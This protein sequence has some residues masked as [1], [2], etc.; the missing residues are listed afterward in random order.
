VVTAPLSLALSDLSSGSLDVVLTPDFAALGLQPA[1]L[2]KEEIDL[3]THVASPSKERHELYELYRDYHEGRQRDPRGLR[4]NDQDRTQTRTFQSVHNVC[5]PLVDIPTERLTVASFRLTGTDGKGDAASNDLAQLLWRWW[6]ASRMDALARIVHRHA[7][8]YG[9][10]Y[11]MV[12]WDALR[13]R[14]RYSI[15]DPLQIEP[16]YDGNGELVAMYKAWEEHPIGESG[17]ITRTRINRYRPGL[18]EKFVSVNSLTYT[19]WTGDVDSDGRPDGGIIP[20]VDA[21]GAPLPIPIVHF[22]N[23]PDGADFGRSDLADAIP[24]QDQFN[25]R[26]WATGQAAIF[27]GARIKYGVNVAAFVDPTTGVQRDPPLGPNAW[28]YLKP[29]DPNIET[30]V[31]SI[32]PGDVAQLQEVADRELKT[33]AGLLGIPMHLIW[34]AG[35]LP[36][37]ESLKTAEA[38]LVSK[39]LDRTITLG[40]GWEDAQYLAIRLANV[41]GAAGLP[42][43]RMCTAQWAP[44]ETRSELTDEQVISLKKDDL[45][46]RQRMRERA[47]S[48][49]DIE[50]VEAER[51]EDRERAPMSVMSPQSGG[52]PANAEPMTP[53]PEPEVPRGRTQ[54]RT[55]EG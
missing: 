33:I 48:E 37:G 52:V 41:F 12:E 20:W 28:W 23:Q 13:S 8:R 34:P 3:A 43:D 29:D 50:R 19:Y 7:F 9:D 26:T 51:E 35:G 31:G 55:A 25:V 10:A 6:Q 16:V 54:T 4:W 1:Q 2:S 5:G 24:M 53:N 46:W 18:I 49:E 39:L 30:V 15:Q 27:D 45:S 32:E 14:P 40:N 42:E 21:A 17:T 38:R 36:S 47:Y 44:V 11:L 22:R